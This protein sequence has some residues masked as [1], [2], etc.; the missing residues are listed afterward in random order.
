[1]NKSPWVSS[2]R[3]R[4]G[5]RMVYVFFLMLVIA[6]T[7][8]A[9]EGTCS[10]SDSCQKAP[11]TSSTED[12]NH[13]EYG[14]FVFVAPIYHP[15]GP[16]A[17]KDEAKD[18]E[19]FIDEHFSCL[20]NPDEMREVCPKSCYVCFENGEG[21]NNSLVKVPIGKQQMLPAEATEEEKLRFDE[22]V[23]ETA[24]YMVDEVFAKKEFE[25]ARRECRNFVDH[26]AWKVAS[27]NGTFCDEPKS[28]RLCGP[29][30]KA[31]GEIILTEEEHEM[32]DECRIDNEKNI[33]VDIGDDDFDDSR[34]LDAM[35]RRIVGELPYPSSS[36]DPYPIVPGVNYTVKV[37]S[38]PSLNPDIHTNMSWDLIDF[39]IGGSW[40]VVLDDFLTPEECDRM[41]ELGDR[42]GRKKSTIEYEEE[43]EEEEDEGE[44]RPEKDKISDEPSWRTSTTA[45]CNKEICDSDPIAKRIHE[46]IGYTTGV[47]DQ[48][49]Y[50][51]FQL[52]KYG[53]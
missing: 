39:Y 2:R 36:E 20:L 44:E 27:T 48:A 32:L 8:K 24:S 14:A 26:C 34:T 45:W 41:I 33:F 40:I 12:I 43:E 11:S 21:S 29:A 35:F 1:M 28:Q 18:C 16:G 13:K 22:V 17:C 5:S 4:S 30:C 7:A 9:S 38:R 6:G 10:A 25:E 52:L 19:E 23:S 42:L 31:C 3:I 15:D 50:E 51:D 46:R 37:L 53:A 47:T 49:Y